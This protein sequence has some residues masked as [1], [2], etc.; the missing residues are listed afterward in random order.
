MTLNKAMWLLNDTELFGVPEGYLGFIYLITNLSTDKKYVGQKGFFS[1]VTKPP[2]KGKS[3][4]RHSVKESDWQ[5]YFGSS[6][7]LKADVAAMGRGGFRREILHLCKSKTELNW[8]ELLEQIDRDVLNRDDYYNGI[9]H[10]RIT[11]V[12]YWSML[13]SQ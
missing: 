5:E 8:M 1:K 10:A 7:E 12:A 4:K 6:A 13:R 2:L 3:L 11:K 9:I